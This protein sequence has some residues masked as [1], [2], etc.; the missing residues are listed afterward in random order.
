MERHAVV[1]FDGQ[2]QIARQVLVIRCDS[3]IPRFLELDEDG[4]GELS[5][6][7]GAVRCD[8]F[9]EADTA[10]VTEGFTVSRFTGVSDFWSRDQ[11]DSFQTPLRVPAFAGDAGVPG[12]CQRHGDKSDVK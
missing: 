12:S 6:E 10:V 7:D 8:R 1:T 5:L 2:C 3:D 4:S 11:E 9:T